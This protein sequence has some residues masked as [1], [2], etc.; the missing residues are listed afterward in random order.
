MEIER[1]H[2][3]NRQHNQDL[4]VFRRVKKLE[5]RVSFWKGCALWAA[6]LLFVVL[7]FIISFG[8]A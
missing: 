3:H 4:A 2:A 7:C 5:E 8:V 6:G 1:D